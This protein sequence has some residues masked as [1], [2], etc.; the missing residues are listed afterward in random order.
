MLVMA[1]R[2]SVSRKTST[3]ERARSVRILCTVQSICGLYR[4]S[5]GTATADCRKHH[6][7]P[8]LTNI[9]AYMYVT[10]CYCPK[11]RTHCCGVV[12]H[13][14]RSIC[15]FRK[16]T[17][18]KSQ[19]WTLISPCLEHPD[20]SLQLPGR[21]DLPSDLAP[22]P[23]P[24]SCSVY[25]SATSSGSPAAAPLSP[26]GRTAAVATPGDVQLEDDPYLS[27]LSSPAWSTAALKPPPGF[28]A[29]RPSKGGGG[30]SSAR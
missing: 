4:S 27:C 1:K 13:S 26:V 16:G 25:F 3:Y 17:S 20:V 8:I 22:S 11:Y 19:Q 5:H 14:R 29:V 2:V 24:S 12:V 18:S 10:L 28:E 15:V 30:Y 23:T 6:V 7:G 9:A 21:L